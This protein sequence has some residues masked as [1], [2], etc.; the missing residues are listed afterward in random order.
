MAEVEITK[1]RLRKRTAKAGLTRI[2]TFLNSLGEEEVDVDKVKVRLDKLDELWKSISTA[3]LEL[4]VMED[5]AED[6]LDEEL[7]ALEDRYFNLKSKGEKIIRNQLKPASAINENLNQAIAVDSNERRPNESHIRLPKID[8]PIFSGSYNDW[9]PFF[10]TFNSLIHS[11]KSL[12]DIQRFH[13]LKSS[14]KGEAAETVSS[15]EISSVNYADTWSRLKE[16]YDNN[17]LAVQNHIRAIFDL[18]IA[19]KENSA[20]IRTVLDGV[21]KHTRAL[22]ALKRPTNQGDDLLIHI[23]TS[24]LDLISIREWENSLDPAQV[25]TFQ[26][27]TDFLARRCQTLEA[28]AGRSQ[29]GQANTNLRPGNAP[30]ITSSHAAVASNK[31]AHCKGGHQIYQCPQFQGL[32]VPERF[33]QVRVKGLCLNCLKGGHLARD[34]T[35]KTCKKC[36]KRHNTLL[37]EE[38]KDKPDKGEETSQS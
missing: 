24:K 23:V 4:A 32:T 31:C 1:L 38:R 33:K 5:I 18:P 19:R 12:N 14:L 6:Q 9:H 16:G 11:N 28:V 2:E 29:V 34:C 27:L 8:L 25:P 3:H 7:E 22:Q 10:D 21:L 36:E 26:G 15:L 20:V 35:S 13:Y 37:H 30:K 17:R